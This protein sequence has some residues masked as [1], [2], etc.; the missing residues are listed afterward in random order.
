MNTT[1]QSLL[2]DAAGLTLPDHS[3]FANVAEL[4][5]LSR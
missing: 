4:S 5:S 1:I 2:R 3:G